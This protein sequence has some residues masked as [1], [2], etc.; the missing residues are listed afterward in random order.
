MLSNLGTVGMAGQ[1][2]P[3]LGN[4]TEVLSGE[5]AVTE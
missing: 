5:F 4:F 1:G 3:C 2:G